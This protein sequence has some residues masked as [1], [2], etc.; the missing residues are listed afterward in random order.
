[1]V[2]TI[3][4][5]PN[6]RRTCVAWEVCDSRLTRARVA[7]EGTGG[8]LWVEKKG[9]RNRR[10]VDWGCRGEMSVEGGA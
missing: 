9:R 1:M 7:V 4:R 3:D 2:S 8:R 5:D 10:L 6:M